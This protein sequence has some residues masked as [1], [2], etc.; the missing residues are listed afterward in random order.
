[1]RVAGVDERVEQR[2]PPLGRDKVQKA[3]PV[4]P[5]PT[6]VARLA[7]GLRRPIC[8]SIKLGTPSEHVGGTFATGEADALHLV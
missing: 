4:A 7:P 3:I 1:V 2:A 6:C 8:K 5:S